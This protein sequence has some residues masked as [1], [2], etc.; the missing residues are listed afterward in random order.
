MATNYSKPGRVIDWTNG[1]GASV[2]SGI[3]VA[4]GIDQ[5]GIA[6]GTIANA[7]VGSVALDG[8]FTLAK[9]A[10]SDTGAL[11]VAGQPAYW[12][13]DKVYDAPGLGRQ[14]IG[15]FAA[16][17][18][19]A[20]TTCRVQLRPFRDEGPRLLALTLSANLAVTAPDLASGDLALLLSNGAAR[21]VTLPSVATIPRGAILK[22][23]K[24]GGG[25]HALTLDPAGDETIA[26]NATHATID[27]DND[28]AEF[29]S[30]G[31]A[32]LLVRSVIA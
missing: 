15:V 2:A 32:W 20:A 31:A 30:T 8:E 26:G 22:V 11:G 29:Q 1:T 19:K 7:A 23:R 27:A 24:T 5:M 9:L 10:H 16:A 17:A 13:T 14:Y 3:P 4:Y 12:L 28:H 18:T 25:A 21:T 6:L